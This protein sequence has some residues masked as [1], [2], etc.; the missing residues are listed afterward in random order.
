MASQ[1]KP[2]LIFVLSIDTEEEW[3][4]SG[5]FPEKDFSVDNVQKLPLLQS[6]CESLNIRPTYFV[7]YAVAANSDAAKALR[8]FS[9]SSRCE[10]GA[11]LHP[12]CNPPYFGKTGEKESHVI[13]LPV[14]HIE[15]KLD[16]LIVILKEQLNVIPKS[17]R[18]GR[19]GISSEVLELL[20]KKCFTIDSSMYPFYKNEFFSCENARLEPYWPDYSDPIQSG[21]QRNIIEFPVTVGFNRKYYQTMLKIYNVLS[22]PWLKPLHLIGILWQTRLLRKLYLSPEVTSG[23]DMKPLVDFAIDNHHPV[24]HMYMHSSSLIDDAT[25]FMEGKNTFDTICSNITQIIEYAHR[26][27][28]IK[29]CTISEAATILQ[30]RS[31]S[32]EAGI[33]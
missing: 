23:E 19:W 24:I 7:D 22:S 10:I 26:K 14:D 1:Q 12:W 20:V 5:D 33:V 17:F 4:W 18:T 9:D 8:S 27:S 11:H 32:A 31:S 2:D 3:D 6:F 30:N 29:F 21:R 16:E 15:Q 28:N 25:G 13:N